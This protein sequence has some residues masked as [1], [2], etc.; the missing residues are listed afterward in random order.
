MSEQCVFDQVK[1]SLNGR[2]DQPIVFGVCQALSKRYK[3]APW[4]FRLAAIVLT[5]IWT[6][7]ALAVYIVLSLVLTETEM[8][9]RKFFSGLAVVVREQVEKLPASLRSLFAQDDDRNSGSRG[10]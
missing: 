4:V 10:Y 9:T 1:E 7:P 5:L 2:P 8:R 3:Q 6:I